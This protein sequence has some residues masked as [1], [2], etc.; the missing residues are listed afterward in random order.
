MEA[1]ER[2]WGGKAS[3]DCETVVR[4]SSRKTNTGTWYPN[5]EP[6]NPSERARG[7]FSGKSWQHLSVSFLRSS[8][9]P[10]I[11][12]ALIRSAGIGRHHRWGRDREINHQIA[13]I[14]S[15]TMKNPKSAIATVRR[16]S[17]QFWKCNSSRGA[18]EVKTANEIHGRIIKKPSA[19]CCQIGSRVSLLMAKRNEWP[20]P[21]GLYLPV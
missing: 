7:K 11:P 3:R 21:Y 17:G 6:P 9:L 13:K 20:R 14:A 2:E 8:F 12:P 18:S 15:A 10:V 16:V 1:N 19:Y 5:H 4:L